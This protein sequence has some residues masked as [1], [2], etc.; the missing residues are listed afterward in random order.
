MPRRRR[1]FEAGSSVHVAARGALGAPIF[2]DDS[3]RR[4]FLT[5]YASV[6]QRHRWRLLAH[7]L[8][9]NHYH[10]LLEPPTST[11]SKGMQLLNGQ[12]AS[13]FNDRHGKPGCV[14]QGRFW[15]GTV[16]SERYLHAVVRYIGIN[17]VKAGM[18]TRPEDWHWS[19]H[20]EL[21]GI[22][23]PRFV[24]VDR[25]WQLLAASEHADATAYRALLE[26]QPDPLVELSVRSGSELSWDAVKR[27]V[28]LLGA[29]GHGAGELARAV[30]RD[31][32]TVQRWLSDGRG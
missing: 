9:P 7:C 28:V 30:G 13:I 10:L 16:D 31:K 22:D 11:L 19:G 2:Q 12:Y 6:A 14:F 4:R 27:E 1:Q 15:S 18:R 21:A 23:Q 20:R 32:R 3:D 25:T 24:D 29:A 26:R 17:P 5:L 8:M